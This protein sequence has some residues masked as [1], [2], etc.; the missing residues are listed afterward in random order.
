MNINM[1]QKKIEET[2]LQL[3]ELNEMRQMYLKHF[4]ENGTEPNK[5]NTSAKVNPN[6][7]YSGLTIKAAAI[8]CLQKTK[9]PVNARFVASEI[10]DVPESS[11]KKFRKM[12]Y[13]CWNAMYQQPA[14]AKR[15]ADGEWLAIK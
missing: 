7:V 11:T 5:R 13:S 10:F 14:L 4:S 15:N 6:G 2:A 3:R 9:H 1:I 12:Y 8:Q